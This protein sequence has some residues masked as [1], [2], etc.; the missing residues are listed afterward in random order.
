MARARLGSVAKKRRGSRG[1]PRR[2]LN[3]VLV[4]LP[5]TENRKP[6][7]LT[8]FTLSLV[9]KGPPFNASPTAP[10]FPRSSVTLISPWGISEV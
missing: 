9:L 2:F 5:K 8:A 6:L 1:L 7:Y 4:F 10:L 3:M